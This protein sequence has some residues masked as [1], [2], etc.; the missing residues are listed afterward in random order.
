M[1]QT[2]GGVTSNLFRRRRD[3]GELQKRRAGQRDRCP[4]GNS[5]AAH[6]AGYLKLPYQQK[7]ASFR[8][9]TMI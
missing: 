6:V 5:I 8:S 1:M 7:V 9:L 4:S 2:A 3:G